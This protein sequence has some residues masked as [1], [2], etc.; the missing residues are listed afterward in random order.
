MWV[1]TRKTGKKK[2][3]I[4]ENTGMDSVK[5]RNIRSETKI[6]NQ[7]NQFSHY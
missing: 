4:C 7:I 3:I 2:E 5:C 1:I 6:L